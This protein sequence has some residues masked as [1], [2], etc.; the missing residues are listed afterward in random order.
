[1]GPG[2]AETLTILRE[3]I[4]SPI[5]ILASPGAAL[6]SVMEQIGINRVSFG[7]Y[8]F[9]SCL[10]KFVGI[11]DVLH[12]HG[13]YDCFGSEMLSRTDVNQFLIHEHE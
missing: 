8:I 7:P 5:N 13:D 1:M 12:G 11:V 9:R 4:Q 6:L 10:Q 3:R 2:D